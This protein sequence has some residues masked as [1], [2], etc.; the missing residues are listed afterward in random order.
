MNKYIFSLV[1]L[2]VFALT[3]AKTFADKQGTK[4]LLVSGKGYDSPYD[5]ITASEVID[6]D[7]DIG[8][9]CNGWTEYPMEIS[10][11]T[12]SLVNIASD[13]GTEGTF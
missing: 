10:S 2:S 3:R 11:G 9:D 5:F 6:L 13:K 7:G 1:L 12:G 4:V 8:D